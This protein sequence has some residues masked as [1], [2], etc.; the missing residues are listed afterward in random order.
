MIKPNA[1]EI[2]YQNRL[3]DR[4]DAIAESK[5]LQEKRAAKLQHLLHKLMRGDSLTGEEGRQICWD[6]LANAN[7]LAQN[8]MT[9]NS[10]TYFRLGQQ[11]WARS[12]TKLMK[13]TDL[14]LAHKMEH[15]AM[16]R[17]HKEE[18]END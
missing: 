12:M 13:N 1:R 18:E 11:S 16:V 4:E 5:K 3:A 14:K 10:Q 15:E 9:G 2:I 6:L 8:P 7:V 17:E